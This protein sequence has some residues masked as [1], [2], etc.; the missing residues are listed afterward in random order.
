MTSANAEPRPEQ[1]PAQWAVRWFVL[2]ATAALVLVVPLFHLGWHVV[3]GRDEPPLRSRGHGAAPSPAW[4]TF[5]D[6]SWMLAGERWLRE[7]SPIVWSLR[8]TW[9]ELLWRAG[10]PQSDAVH[11]GG[12]RWL[13]LASEREPDLAAF[14]AGAAVRVAS[15]RTVQ[16]RVRAAGAELVVAVVPDKSRVYAEFA[17][18]DGR[19]GSTKAPIYGELLRDLAD[20]GVATTDLAAA[21][22]EARS[23]APHEE[24]YYRGDTHWRP[25]GALVAGRAIAA[26]IEAAPWASRLA[27]RARVTL[28]SRTSVPALGD[29]V[30]QAGF[31]T[32]EVP[33]ATGTS[34][35]ALSLVG[36]GFTEPRD[37]Y[38]AGIQ[39][40]TDVVPLTGKDADAEVWLIG[41]SFAGENGM[42][43]LMLALGRP[44]RG[45]LGNGATGLSPMQTALAELADP[46]TAVRP[47]LVVWELVERGFSEPGWRQPR[48]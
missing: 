34:T 44:V 26:A 29:L 40:P 21:F 45:V 2:V 18:A 10:V 14:R 23:L 36:L 8:S 39:G 42:Q 38:G 41:T 11:F 15:F 28:L 5:R 4:R 16:A 7:C 13:F 17:W 27:P 19:I 43:A 35:V 47:K 12:D 48:W 37:Y 24:L 32:I 1:T 33:A 9:N 46:A 30:A 6:G 22:A 3:A 20:A 31:A 25:A